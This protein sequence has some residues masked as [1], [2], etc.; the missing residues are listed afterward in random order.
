MSRLPFLPFDWDPPCTAA[1]DVFFPRGPLDEALAKRVC[2][3]CAVQA[4]C[5]A[6]ALT[7]PHLYGIWGATTEAERDE[8]TGFRRQRRGRRG[9]RMCE[10]CA[11]VEVRGPARRFCPPC[12]DERDRARKRAYNARAGHN[13]PDPATPRSVYERSHYVLHRFTRSA[14]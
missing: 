4:A 9:T 7:E 10:G 11:S 3:R 2:A 14:S 1:P 13:A 8:V 5:A 12:R 6:F